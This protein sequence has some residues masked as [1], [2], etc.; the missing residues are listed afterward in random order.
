MIRKFVSKNILGIPDMDIELGD[1]KIVIIKGPNG[2]GKTSLLKQ[3]THPLSSHDRFNRLKPGEEEGHIITYLTYKNRDYK[4]QH[5]YKRD[6]KS[7]KVLS[8]LAKKIDNNYVELVD[9]GLP[10]KFTDIANKELDYDKYMYDILNI[11][12]SNKGLVDGTNVERIEYLKKILKLDILDNIKNNVLDNL[13]ERN[14]NLKYIKNKLSEFS[15][16]AE[17]NN[18]RNKLKEV[19][20]DI[21]NKISIKEKELSKLNLLEDK[22]DS[23]KDELFLYKNE[24]SDLSNIKNIL[25]KVDSNISLEKLKDEIKDEINNVKNNISKYDSDIDRINSDLMNIKEVDITSLKKEKESLLNSIDIFKEKYSDI[26]NKGSLPSII[27]NETIYEKKRKVIENIRELSDGYSLDELSE[28]LTEYDNLDLM[29]KEVEDELDKVREEIFDDKE[30]L[31]KINLSTNLVNKEVPSECEIPKCPLR[32]ELERQLKELDVYN[33]LNKNIKNNEENLDRLNDN[34]SYVKAKYK[35]LKRIKEN[36]NDINYDIKNGSLIL[37]DE[38]YDEIVKI[39]FFIKDNKEYDNNLKNLER[40][41][42]LI[43]LDS[44][45]GSGKR[46]KLLSEIKDLSFKKDR[47]TDILMKLMKKEKEV[48]ISLNDYN[49]LSIKKN[50]LDNHITKVNNKIE[51]LNNSIRNYSNNKININNLK[52]DIKKLKEKLQKITDEYYRLDNNISSI[53]KYTLE[54]EETEKEVNE[55]SILREIINKKLPGKI[56]ENFLFDVA[57]SVNNLLEDFMTIRFDI[58]E[59]IDILVNRDGIERLASDLSQGEKSILA[60]ALLM[61]FKKNVSWDII[62]FDELDATLDESNKDKFIYMLRDYS[63][64]INSLSQIFIVTHTDFQ[65]DGMDMKVIRL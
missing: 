18:Q 17:I 10:T 33:I 6:K 29:V 36:L 40:V 62:S 5:L 31:N 44:N 63:E 43:E 20:I 9:N 54:F 35:S 32:L 2:S 59:G 53:K 26:L 25:S 12:V 61:V 8:Y 24:L 1:E 48:N 34:Y 51:E 50:D 23:L 47:E 46:D 65:D 27:E 22:T 58:K 21:D 4:I 41:N 60:M 13:K 16:L 30:K 19:S 64:L 39:L 49:N 38:E 56:L 42:T 52:E 28:N 37:L 55:L 7:V 45:V 11:G 3:I 14:A 57:N 15:P